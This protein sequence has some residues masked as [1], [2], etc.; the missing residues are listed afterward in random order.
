M[1]FI[2]KSIFVI[3]PVSA[4]SKSV[5][6]LRP[7]YLTVL[8]SVRL[9]RQA[10]FHF[11]RRPI[12]HLN[13]PRNFSFSFSAEKSLYLHRTIRPSSVCLA[14]ANYFQQLK[15]NIRKI[16]FAR[17]FIFR[18]FWISSESS[19]FLLH[20]LS[21]CASLVIDT[22]VFVYSIIYLWRIYRR[23]ILVNKQVVYT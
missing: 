7:S 16:W 18:T 23:I 20:R 2:E 14:W 22:C 9:T 10:L 5:P 13:V 21:Q 11:S 3:V 12:N 19:S 4:R 17:K 8:P 15:V 6:R 1:K